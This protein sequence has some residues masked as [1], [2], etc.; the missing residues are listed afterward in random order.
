MAATSASPFPSASAVTTQPT[1]DD[2][3]KEP[4]VHAWAEDI[5]DPATMWEFLAKETDNAKTRV[6][7]QSIYRDFFRTKPFEG[8][9]IAEH[10]ATLT[11]LRNQI[12]GTREA[13]SD[14]SFINHVYE[15]LPP[16]YDI[17]IEVQ[18]V[19]DDDSLENILS[20]FRQ[21]EKSK[22]MLN[23]SSKS[24]ETPS[25]E[26]AH[27]SKWSTR[28]PSNNDSK[29]C[30]NCNTR[31][32]HTRGCWSIPGERSLRKDNQ[33]NS[34]RRFDETDIVCYYYGGAGHRIVNCPVKSEAMKARENQSKRFKSRDDQAAHIT[35]VE[36]EPRDAYPNDDD[37]PGL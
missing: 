7:R 31:T 36:D 17:A 19:K 28:N 22:A 34:K 2:L 16:A 25:S 33:N 4:S 14:M 26:Q 12:A 15:N 1:P 11:K 29:W 32:H 6:G 10:F 24:A 13:I 23:R 30:D 3:L 20:A 27:Y 21:F 18:Q 37:G 9:P 8:R 35:A 5:D